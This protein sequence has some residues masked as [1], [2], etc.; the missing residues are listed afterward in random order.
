MFSCPKILLPIPHPFLSLLLPLSPSPPSCPPLS[1]SSS[2]TFLIDEMDSSDL[3]YYFPSF[4]RGSLSFS[5]QHNYYCVCKYFLFSPL[6]LSVSSLFPSYSSLALPPLSISLFFYP[7]L[8]LPTA[9][10]LNQI[11]SLLSSFQE[12]TLFIKFINLDSTLSL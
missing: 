2:L 7:F 4:P 9:I 5:H 1:F 10:S 8:S 11:Q 3:Y 6:P 12:D